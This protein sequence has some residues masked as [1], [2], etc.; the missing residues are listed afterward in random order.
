MIPTSWSLACPDHSLASLIV[1]ERRFLPGPRSM[2]VASN[3]HPSST[4]VAVPKV[5]LPRYGSKPSGYLGRYRWGDLNRR[6]SVLLIT[7][8]VVLGT[9]GTTAQ[10]E[11]KVGSTPLVAI[12]GGELIVPLIST[13]G[14]DDWPLSLPV[15]IGGS[16][17]TAT[18]AWL[19]PRSPSV[20]A[21][22]TPAS[23]VSIV[24]A[25]QDDGPALTGNAV[26]IFPVPGDAD[27][28]IVL[29]GERWAPRWLPSMQIL[30]FDLEEIDFKGPDADPVLDD[31]MEWFR[32]VLLA[33]I[34]NRRPPLPRLGTG[35]DAEIGRRVAISIASEWKA[36]LRR[37]ESVSPGVAK[38]IAERLVATVVDERRA[39]G[40][41]FVAAWPTDPR[42]LASL[43]LLLLDP[44]RTALE[45]AQA[46]LAWFEA[47]PAFLAW[48][49]ANASSSVTVELANPTLGELVVLAS[50]ADGSGVAEAIVLPPRSLI[51]HVVERPILRRGAM[52]SR[53][54]LDLK[55]EQ[56][57][58]RLVFPNRAIP[59][60]PPGG[61]FGSI[62]FS[63]T[64]AA[65]NGGYVELPPPQFGT[66][67]IL[68]RRGLRWQVFIDARTVQPDL[69]DRIYLVFGPTDA[70]QA[71]LEVRSSGSFEVASSLGQNGLQVLVRRH[72]DRWRAEIDIPE[73][74]L[75]N[76]ISDSQAGAV[77]I[78]LRRDGPGK[79]VSYAGPPPPAWRREIP[80][81]PF[82]I[83][84]WGRPAS[85][86][87]SGPR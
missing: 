36:G 17:Q 78:G 19:V 87:K 40:D 33:D 83:T 10:A 55:V 20:P 24:L 42:E 60:R 38:E 79:L 15:V 5:R 4:G 8:L 47:R 84:G 81:Q 1:N 51:N 56:R 72:P 77:L 12:R 74:W 59:V 53:E 27:G 76:S 63:L 86:A 28:E 21:W 75:A 58:R 52:S 26:A 31:P 71:Q 30:D 68:R 39:M 80:V 48:T 7:V 64:L 70:P 6:F 16:M 85:P 67:A 25:D 34:A 57:V 73:S 50:W 37:I 14:L 54:T 23:P 69:D 49:I 82:A 45:A 22:T 11:I 43:R 3:P 29:L 18:V 13:D 41:R 9:T 2:S 32:W 44:D 35:P 62:A 66:G 46:G 61:G 65:A